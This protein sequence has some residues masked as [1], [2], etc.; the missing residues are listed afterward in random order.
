[1]NPHLTDDDVDRMLDG[2]LTNTEAAGLREHLT[3]CDACRERW[4]AMLGVHT[5]LTRAESAVPDGLA[6]SAVAAALRPR[7]APRFQHWF[8]RAALLLMGVGVGLAAGAIMDRAP[9]TA[10]PQPR[11]LFVF[12]GS[13]S[14]GMTRDELASI[15]REFR[16]WM[17]SLDRQRVVAADGQ[18]FRGTLAVIPAVNPSLDSTSLGALGAMEGMLL[19]HAADDSVAVALARTCPFLRYGGTIVVR[20]MMSPAPGRSRS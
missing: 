6:A 10:P 2:T 14:A 16:A 9:A 1:V 20:R 5:W 15:G 7:Q 13:R 8:A 3:T 12:S 18:L 19:V 4:G 11:Y 17:D